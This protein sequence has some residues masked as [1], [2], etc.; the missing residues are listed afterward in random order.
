MGI[1]GGEHLTANYTTFQVSDEQSLYVLT[2]TGFSGE[3]G[4]KSSKII[5]FS[6]PAFLYFIT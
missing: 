5:T 6:R 2:V 4:S 1:S 3:A